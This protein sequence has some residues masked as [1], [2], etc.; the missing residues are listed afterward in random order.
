MT[1]NGRW[2]WHPDYI[3]MHQS[4]YSAY[5]SQWNYFS[6]TGQPTCWKYTYT[7]LWA[8][9]TMYK[10]SNIENCLIF[11]Q[12]WN[13][14]CCSGD[15]RHFGKH[16]PR[17]ILCCQSKTIR[18]Y[19]VLITVTRIVKIIWDVYVSR[20]LMVT[21]NE[22]LIVSIT[23]PINVFIIC[24]INWWLEKKYGLSWLPN[25]WRIWAKFS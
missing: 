22:M 18:M 23:C 7:N 11:I 16:P 5:F 20:K 1:V 8:I 14:K 25:N 12:H 15:H 9:Y 6:H 10:C 2:Q 13:L 4:L 3:V 21:L 24:T 17:D 19:S